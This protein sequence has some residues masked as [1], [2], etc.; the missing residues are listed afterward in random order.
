M[1][2]TRKFVMPLGVAIAAGTLAAGGVTPA[3]AAAPSVTGTTQA[4][5]FVGCASLYS[6]KPGRAQ[7][8]N[9]CSKA[10]DATVSVDWSWD[11]SCIRINPG[12]ILSITWNSTAGKAEYAYEC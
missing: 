7:I 2:R 3:V 9:I 4:T 11:P 5:S 10:I 6:N 8:K 1:S 12:R